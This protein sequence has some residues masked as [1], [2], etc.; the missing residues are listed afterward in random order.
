MT[1]F[2]AL[3]KHRPKIVTLAHYKIQT[4]PKILHPKLGVVVRSSNTDL[5]GW[6][7]R[8]RALSLA[9]VV[10]FRRVVRETGAWLTMVARVGRF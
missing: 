2:A 8:R 6:L 9:R 5:V 1:E 3:H 7:L 4:T 10:P